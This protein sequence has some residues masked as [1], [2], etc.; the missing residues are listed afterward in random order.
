M[1]GRKER[2]RK[3]GGEG[4]VERIIF[5]ACAVTAAMLFRDAALAR[6]LVVKAP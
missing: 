5:R 4:G 3:K 1:K 2:D 6:S